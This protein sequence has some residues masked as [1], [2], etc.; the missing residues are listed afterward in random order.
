VVRGFALF[1]VL[2]E[3]MYG[4]GADSIAWSSTADRAAFAIM[5]VFVESK[6]WTLF[7][8]LFGLGFALQLERADSSGFSFLPAYLRRLAVLFVLGAAHALLFDGDILM[9]YAELGLALLVVRRL[10]VRVLL[11]LA[12]LL[13]LA[14]PVAHLASTRER[15]AGPDEVQTARARLER[16]RRSDVY[17]VGSFA[18]VVADNADAIPADPLEDLANPESGLAVFAMLLIGY[19]IGRSGVLRDIPGHAAA[20]ARVR[21]WGL[22]LGLGAMLADRALHVTAG[23]DVFRTQRAGPGIRF[24]GDVLFAYGITALALGYAAALVLAAQTPRGKTALA[25]LAVI[26]R[27]TLTAYLTQTLMFTTLF[28]GYGFGQVY[29]LGPVAVTG[30]A[31]AFFALQLLAAQWWSRRF[32]L[33]PFEWLWRSL[34][35]LKWQPM[36]LRSDP[37]N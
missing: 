27:L 16:A 25:P 7:S 17:A 29:R 30:W 24:V 8:M 9:L 37:T 28:Y 26:G 22:G 33:G 10:P 20:I 13:L 23:Y 15:L 31:V 35:Y 12:A 34:T 3:N 36:R 11:V 1:G 21:S 19:A 14:F 2:L 4:F 5:H 32:R 6:T 18:E